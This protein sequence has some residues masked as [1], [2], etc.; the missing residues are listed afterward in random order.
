MWLWCSN[1]AAVTEPVALLLSFLLFLLLL[2]H[3]IPS[4][5]LTWYTF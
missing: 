4:L 2:Q 1:V 5:L 3:T